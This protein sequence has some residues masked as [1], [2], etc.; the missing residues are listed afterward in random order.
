MRNL[1]I[2][3]LTAGVLLSA[4][5]SR[6]EELPAP[7]PS[8]T[9]AATFVFGVPEAEPGSRTLDPSQ[10]SAVADLNLYIFPSGS[11][12][13]TEHRYQPALQPLTL[14]LPPG[15][16]D[17]YAVANAGRDLGSLGRTDLETLSLLV[18]SED[19]IIS[20]HRLA[21][22][23]RHSFIIAGAT[24]V[25]VGLVRLAARLTL[26]VSTADAFAGFTLRSVQVAG[27]PR[28]MTPFA[29]GRPASDGEVTAWPR[30]ELAGRSCSATFYLPENAQ[31]EVSSITD[32]RQRSRAHA[33]EYA[34]CIHIEGEASGRKVD[35][36]IYPG[37]NTTSNFDIL[38]NRRYTLDV[39]ISGVNRLD[40][41]LSTLGMELSPLPETCYVGEEVF[42]DLQVESTDPA[43]VYRLAFKPGAE[44]DEA[45]LD[46]APLTPGTF[47]PLFLGADIHTAR[48][49]YRPMTAGLTRP[50]FVL[51]DGYGYE[52]SRTLQTEAAEKPSLGVTLTPP[53]AVIIGRSAV[54]TLEIDGCDGT[55]VCAFACSDPQS[56]FVFPAGTGLSNDQ[57]VLG[58]GLH[59]I[60]LDTRTVGELTV[61]VQASD[62]GGRVVQRECTVT[63]RY[64]KS[65]ALVRTVA[66]ANLYSDSPMTLTIR[67]TE[68]SGDYT[69][70]YTTTASDCRVSYNGTSLAP[71]EC[72]TLGTGQHTFTANSSCAERTAFTFTVTDA[73]GQ[74]YEAQASI[75]WR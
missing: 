58:N 46:G 2:L 49:G 8:G 55:A 36:Y 44:G 3:S 48:I 56:V 43:G 40:M 45:T 25:H 63:S 9:S 52:M 14:P 5:C 20:G 17:L 26:N 53:S 47:V 62:G 73:F 23:A 21:M 39:M 32:P 13:C 38:R 72:L 31:G 50:E 57:A 4:A 42:S 11:D 10:E 60:L 27:V 71:G 12:V 64:P 30:H 6:T 41:R 19:E 29:A 24:T 37:G 35:Y 59:D 61:S 68:Y 7:V 65:S 16:Y 74:S 15:S 22:A 1:W 54:F 51:C 75:T 66:T 33:P 28:G 69:V 70:S 67:S 34:T 18:G